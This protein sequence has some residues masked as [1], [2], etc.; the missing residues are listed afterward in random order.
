MNRHVSWSVEKPERIALL[1]QHRDVADGRRRRKKIV[2]QG[3]H[4]ARLIR[5]AQFEVIGHRSRPGGLRL[6]RILADV[7]A[8]IAGGYRKILLK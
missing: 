8:L 1:D 7:A 4:V 2:Q 6:P 5:V 3:V